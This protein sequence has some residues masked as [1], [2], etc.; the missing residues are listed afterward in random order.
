MLFRSVNYTRGDVPY[1]RIIEHKHF[2]FGTQPKTV[3]TREYPAP[4]REGD[5]PYYA[6][7][8]QKNDMLAEK[9]KKLAQEKG[10]IL[11]GR[12]ADYRYY[13][14]DAVIENALAL[15]DKLFGK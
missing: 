7:N 4:W 3:I 13:N 11:G 1:T 5:E 9:Y 12:L 10:Y 15:A 6:I 2:E 14:M 8:D